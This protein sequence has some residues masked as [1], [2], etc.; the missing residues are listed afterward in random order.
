M[1]LETRTHWDKALNTLKIYS[2]RVEQGF[3]FDCHHQTSQLLDSFLSEET[4]ILDAGCGAGLMLN[5]L[6][7]KRRP[8]WTGLDSSVEM[9]RLCQKNLLKH[10]LPSH[11]AVLGDLHKIKSRFDC[12]LCINTL[13][14]LP[15]YHQALDLFCDHTS[16]ILI[17]C[18]LD[19]ST[20]IRYTKDP[21]SLESCYYNI[22]SR[23]EIRGFLEPRGFQV[24]FIPDKHFQAGHQTSDHLYH[25][26]EFIL[27]RK[28]P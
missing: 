25:P 24:Q 28:H 11:Q 16:A 14:D 2:D 8:F 26:W 19:E 21:D 18:P 20:H 12:I 10:R 6:A 27:A 15:N 5:A 17:R 13:M 7:E 4:S 23:H 3:I 1:E 9:I 22:Y